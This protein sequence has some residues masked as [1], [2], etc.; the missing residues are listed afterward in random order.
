MDDLQKWRDLVQEAT[1]GERALDQTITRQTPGLERD[2]DRFGAKD[3][4][5]NLTTVADLLKTLDTEVQKALPLVQKDTGSR[6][7]L[8]LLQNINR[9][10]LDRT[11]NQLY[12]LAKQPAEKKEETP[13]AGEAGAGTKP[14]A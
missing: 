2:E 5:S 12:A 13:A 3:T 1:A 11:A 14:A 7:T 10:G 6:P 4:F 9:I 8:A